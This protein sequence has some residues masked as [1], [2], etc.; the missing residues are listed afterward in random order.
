[1]GVRTRKGGVYVD[2]GVGSS[3]SLEARNSVLSFMDIT[4]KANATPGRPL[5]LFERLATLC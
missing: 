4:R 5:T 3:N 1:M 2:C